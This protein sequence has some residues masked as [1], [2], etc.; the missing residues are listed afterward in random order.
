MAYKFEYT[1]QNNATTMEYETKALL[2]LMSD[3]ADSNRIDNY[4]IDCFNDV[5]GCDLNYEEIWD[6]QSKGIKTL[7]PKTIGN[8]LYTLY[9][10]SLHSFP[11]KHFIL[12]IPKLKSDYFIDNSNKIFD[13]NNFK[14]NYIPKIYEGLI[15]EYKK[16]KNIELESKDI[17]NFIN[18][19]TFVVA[20]KTK[21]EYIRNLVKFRS[22]NIDDFYFIEIFNEI[23][24]KQTICKNIPVHNIEIISPN[25]VEK[26][27][28]VIKRKEIYALIVNRFL[29]PSILSPR[30]NVPII[31]NVEIK[32]YNE[33]EQKDIIQE[34][35]SEFARL[36][37]DKNNKINFWKFFEALV[38]TTMKYKEHSIN[39]IYNKL[40]I[41]ELIKLVE[42]QTITI[43]YLIALIKDGL[44]NEN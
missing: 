21:V 17:E 43:K 16:R 26:H 15:Q 37:F 41:S 24:N 10:N 18:S 6:V 34:V 39:E 2:Y 30:Y 1:E 23:S 33:E 35:N 4:V 42:I 8:A 5:S 25:E 44:N 3:R 22:P 20:D 40:N 32:E 12:I 38:V 36:L 9:N 11:F 14:Q 27:K 19:L 7:R 13:I 28:K 29:G 31:F